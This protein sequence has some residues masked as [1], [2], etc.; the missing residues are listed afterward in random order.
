MTG[1]VFAIAGQIGSGKST[2]ARSLAEALGC[3][4]A[5][6]GSY[7]RSEADRLR[8]SDD[9][10]TLQ[11]LGQDLLAHDGAETFCM[12]MLDNQTK[13]FAPGG[14]LVIDGV[15]HLKVADALEEIVRPSLLV[16]VFMKVDRTVRAHRLASR[17][18]QVDMADRHP[19][20]QDVPQ[21]L[22]GRADIALIATRPSGELVR[23]V[24]DW[25]RTEGHLRRFSATARST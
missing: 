18:A 8:Y 4:M 2:F 21:R 13:A 16:L 5:S 23:A 10:E 6:F 1:I 20:E 11:D 14:S 7:V 15:R 25:L 22:R 3:E 19:T 9:R 17:G 24:G 12:A